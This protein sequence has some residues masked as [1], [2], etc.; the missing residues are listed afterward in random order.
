MAPRR[1]PSSSVASLLGELTG[2]N[3][4]RLLAREA[5]LGLLHGVWLG[6]LVAAIALVWQRNPALGLVLGLAMIG[7][8]VVAG[9]VGAAVPL[10]LRRIGVDPAVA[11]AVIVTTFTDVLGF[12]LYLGCAAAAISFLR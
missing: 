3:P 6:V 7:N 4:V 12:M 11:S 5:L 8:M 10:F 2:L 9:F 1:L